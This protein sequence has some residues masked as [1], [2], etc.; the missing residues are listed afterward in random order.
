MPPRQLIS[1]FRRNSGSRPN[2]FVILGKT[3]SRIPFGESADDFPGPACTEC[4]SAVG[5][6][7]EIECALE[8]CPYCGEQVVYCICDVMIGP[9]L[10]RKL[11][12][13][14]EPTT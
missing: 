8:Q 1:I 4:K 6:L 2:E 3:Y 10:R 9:P 5:S 7:H 14:Q 11:N 13:A 12:K